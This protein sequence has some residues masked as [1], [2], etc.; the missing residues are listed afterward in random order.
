MVSYQHRCK[1]EE[2]HKVR[3]YSTSIFMGNIDSRPSS[4][5]ESNG[6]SAWD[7]RRAGPSDR[8][9]RTSVAQSIAPKFSEMA[10]LNTFMTDREKA[11]SNAMLGLDRPSKHQPSTTRT[12]VHRFDRDRSIADLRGCDGAKPS[13]TERPR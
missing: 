11:I 12:D 13:V 4:V 6:T 10:R 3:T 9:K 5:H 1:A 7:G 8:K 2:V